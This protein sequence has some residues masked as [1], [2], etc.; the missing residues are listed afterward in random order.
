MHEQWKMSLKFSY[1]SPL[2]RT[3]IYNVC[4][5]S[6]AF[7]IYYELLFIEDDKENDKMMRLNFVFSLNIFASFARQIIDRLT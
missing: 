4:L 7:S 6:S 1:H 2:N 3:K 5:P